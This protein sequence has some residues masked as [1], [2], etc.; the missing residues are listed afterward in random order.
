MVIAT[1]VTSA[2]VFL[3]ID[4]RCLRYVSARFRVELHCYAGV[5][6]FA[7]STA[8]QQMRVY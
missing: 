5:T 1:I 2:N 8:F 7:F 4:A 3:F 6:S